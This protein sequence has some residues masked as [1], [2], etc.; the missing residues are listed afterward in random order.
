ML[1]PSAFPL[2]AL[3]ATSALANPIQQATSSRSSSPSP[4][5]PRSQNNVLTPF[6]LESLRTFT[7]NNRQYIAFW[8]SD[9]DFSPYYR[10]FCSALIDNT[11]GELAES[12]T[13]EERSWRPVRPSSEDGASTP[14]PRV[15]RL[16]FPSSSDV[17]INIEDMYGPPSLM[18]EE[19][20]IECTNGYW[21]KAMGDVVPEDGNDRFELSVKHILDRENTKGIATGE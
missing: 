4:E 21:F 10:G 7:E 19:G 3:L 9:P 16:A 1:F 2:A 12:D 13:V 8:V 20:Y 6:A 15:D 18:D 17:N 5:E 11:D 14:S